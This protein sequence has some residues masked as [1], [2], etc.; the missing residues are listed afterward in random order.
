MYF[1][2]HCLSITSSNLYN[3]SK[4]WHY[5]INVQLKIQNQRV[6]ELLMLHLHPNHYLSW[7]STFF[8]TLCYVVK[9][10]FFPS[11]EDKARDFP[12]S[13][14]PRFILF[15]LILRY[16]LTKLLRLDL[17]LWSSCL[18]LLRWW[19]YSHTLHRATCLLI[20]V[21]MHIH[22]CMDIVWG[23]GDWSQSLKHARQVL[24]L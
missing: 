18:S 2:Q 10:N 14:M 24:Y 13:C 15:F 4:K 6:I 23:T 3:N 9:K 12:L 17:N 7:K 5:F 1:T 19:S 16:Y 8:L 22:S 20:Y 11:F 21:H